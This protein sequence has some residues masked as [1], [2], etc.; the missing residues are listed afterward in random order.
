[1]VVQGQDSTLKVTVEDMVYNSK[2]VSRGL[3]NSF[4]VTDMPYLSYNI[5]IKDSLYNA[6]KII[7]E[8]NAQAVK[9][10]G[11]KR[12][13][14]TIKRIIDIEIPV[15]GHLGLTPQSVNMMGGFKLQGKSKYEADKIY[16]DAVS[17]EKAGVFCIVLEGIP[18][19]LGKAITKAVNIPTIGIG[20]G[21]YTDGQVLVI[22][23]MLG[24]NTKVPKFVKKYLNGRELLVNS[25]KEYLD[26]VK[27]NKFPAQEHIY[28]VKE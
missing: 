5:D 16:E 27:E 18:E 11:G 15:V 21:R 6:G 19:E 23:D 17:L 9:I 13:I 8:G 24:L 25:V 1:M 3:K 26:E 2:I 10:E 4:L 14:D 22:H 12:S 28:A 7:Q 20:A